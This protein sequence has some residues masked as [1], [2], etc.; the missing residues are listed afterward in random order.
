LKQKKK[1]DR[2]RVSLP[3][4]FKTKK[5]NLGCGGAKPPGKKKKKKNPE[6][7]KKT[8]QKRGKTGRVSYNW[9]PG[10]RGPKPIFPFRTPP[11]CIGGRGRVRHNFLLRAT[12]GRG[13]L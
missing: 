8:P 12:G 6:K 10:M 5:T 9:G 11:L 1:P 7:K 13:E 3:K 4:S 2:A